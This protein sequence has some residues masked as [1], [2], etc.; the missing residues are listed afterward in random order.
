MKSINVKDQAL[1]PMFNPKIFNYVV[2]VPSSINKVVIEANTEDKIN[3]GVIIYKG[4]IE[5][6][7]NIINLDNGLNKIMYHGTE[8]EYETLIK[9]GGVLADNEKFTQAYVTYVTE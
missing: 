8:K 6:Y 1:S 5:I 2:N 9:T 3:Y 4:S 7:G